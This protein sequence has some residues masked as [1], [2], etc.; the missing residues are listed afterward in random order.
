[1]ELFADGATSAAASSQDF[2]SLKF[3][4][5]NWDTSPVRLRCHFG[6]P[7]P[8][9]IRGLSP[10]LTIRQPF[11]RSPSNKAPKERIFAPQFLLRNL[12]SL[13]ATCVFI[14]AGPFIRR[15]CFLTEFQNLGAHDPHPT[16]TSWKRQYLQ[17]EP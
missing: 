7:E 13:E 9:P 11:R 12:V 10:I 2:P 14:G 3:T 4:G 6:L 8:T 15:S 1:M 17:C 16:R 5:F